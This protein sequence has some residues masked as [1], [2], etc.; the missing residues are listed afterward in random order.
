[1]LKLRKKQTSEPKFSR[2][3][4]LK[5]L[6]GVLF[7]SLPDLFT[8]KRPLSLLYWR[9]V[10]TTS[11]V[12]TS[13]LLIITVIFKSHTFIEPLQCE[14]ISFSESLFDS[15][16]F[17]LFPNS[18]SLLVAV[19]MRFGNLVKHRK[20]VGSTIDWTQQW[21]KCSFIGSFLL[22]LISSS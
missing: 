18:R 17:Q 19:W 11:L 6:L 5:H 21:K 16:W 8:D 15:N 2:H 1:M 14:I 12:R 4:S 20:N 9:L 22:I 10:K 7:E 13:F 3:Q